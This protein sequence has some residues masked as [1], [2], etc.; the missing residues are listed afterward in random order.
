MER[1]VATIKQSILKGDKILLSLCL[2]ASGYSLLLIYSATRHV[3]SLRSV[4]V[5]GIT[6]LLGILFYFIITCIDIFSFVSKT[7]RFLL[8]FC[9]GFLLLLKTPLGTDYGQGNLNWLQIP[10]LPIDIQPNEIV[11]IPFLL[12]LS[13][14][15]CRHVKKERALAQTPSLLLLCAYG[16]S[17]IA[18]IILICGDYGT[19]MVYLVIFAFTLW[20]GGIH[21]KWFFFSGTGALAA[22]VCIW[23][24]LLPQTSYWTDYRIMRFRVV[25][26]HNLASQGIGWQQARSCLAIGSGQLWGQGFLSGMQTQALSKSALPVRATDLIFSVCGEE[27]G[28]IG[29]CLLLVILFAI[30]LRCLFLARQASDRFSACCCVA[31]AAMMAAQTIFNV[32]M[33]LYI[34]PVMGLTLPFISY[35][36]SSL[37]TMYAAMGIVSSVH[38][39]P[40]P[41]W[42][43]D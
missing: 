39:H 14:L 5:Q 23:K 34:L 10:M 4:L 20:T 18:L 33:C 3:G 2:I 19:C 37:I 8:F 6:I 25:F 36:G 24:F 21:G 38:A 12:I 29:A 17:V 32:G 15:T 7:H 1:I 27:F 11:K 41:S 28:F 43:R 35:G 26:D 13:F 31:V 40:T 22:I 16:F 9:Y 42:L 30:I